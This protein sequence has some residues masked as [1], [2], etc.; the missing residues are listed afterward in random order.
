M[1][2]AEAFQALRRGAWGASVEWHAAIESTQDAMR[3]RVRHV[4][5]ETGAVIGAEAQSAGRGRWG[6]SWEG[7]VGQSLLFTLAVPT[8]SLKGTL[9]QAPLVLG[10]GLCQAM[11]ALGQRDLA[12]RWPNDLTWKGKKLAGLLVEQE[13]GHLLIG[14]GLNVGQ[15]EEAFSPELQASAASLKQAGSP[16]LRREPLL[17]AVL[18]GL[19]KAWGDWQIDGFEAARVAWESRAEGREALLQVQPT[20]GEAWVG[21]W[22]GLH[23]SGALEVQPSTGPVR[24]L[25][26]GEVQRLVYPR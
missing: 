10:L 1:F 12:L 24:L 11:E 20:A 13:G 4:G 17:A 3:D 26:S 15:D 14:V 16:E 8:A 2:D 5:V 6:R 7:K 19:E 22:A 25:A 9:G 18:R 23:V 21:R